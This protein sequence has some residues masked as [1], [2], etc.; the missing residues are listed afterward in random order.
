MLVSSLYSILG[1]VFKSPGILGNNRVDPSEQQ[2][3]LPQLPETAGARL[4]RLRPLPAPGLHRKSQPVTPG[5]D[6]Y[7]ESL[8]T[9]N[10]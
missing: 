7:L 8:K 2:S 10:F 6:L 5:T 9:S 4:D 3:F 1:N